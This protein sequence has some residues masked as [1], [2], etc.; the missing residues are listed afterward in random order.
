MKTHNKSECYEILD[1]TFNLRIIYNFLGL[2]NNILSVIAFHVFFYL[3]W[4]I[5]AFIEGSIYLGG[6]G[7]GF[8]NALITH[9]IGLLDDLLIY[10]NILAIAI[11]LISLNILIKKFFTVF[12][13]NIKKCLNT[14][15]L[16]IED[17]ETIFD[18]S[19]SSLYNYKKSKIFWLLTVLG[20]SMFFLN[21]W[22]QS[23]LSYTW[24][25]ISD[26]PLGWFLFNTYYFLILVLIGPLLIFK[27]LITLFATRT[28][29]TK[30]GNY[31]S[32]KDTNGK[33]ALIINPYFSKSED[34]FKSIGHYSK[35]VAY[36]AILPLI[37]IPFS[38]LTEGPKVEFFIFTAIG[39]IFAILC[40]FMPMVPFHSILKKVKNHELEHINKKLS[41]MYQSLKPQLQKTIEG[42]PRQ[43]TKELEVI[44]QLRYIYNDWKNMDV[45]PFDL[46]TISK[47][48][49]PIVA[50]SAEIFLQLFIS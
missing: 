32:S 15:I 27:F 8:I 12:R 20:I 34:G 46:K 9:D 23:D 24:H 22:T 41:T 36:L 18:V 38:I 50:L 2:K 17:Y 21:I 10:V 43:S 16:Q 6:D 37:P 19:I 48:F 47:A 44:H 25:Y 35:N 26:C 40:F 3:S 30:I 45:W 13:T 7:S 5:V 11:F 29:F 39:L 4:V 42:A 49:A 14:E 1:D 31:K 28:I 33:I